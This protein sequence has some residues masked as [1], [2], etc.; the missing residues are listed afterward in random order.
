MAKIT[1]LVNPENTSE[2]LYPITT[3]EAVILKTGGVLS[4]V[5]TEFSEHT[6]KK[7]NP[8]QVTAA[9]IGLGNVTNDAQVKRSEM[10]IPGGVAILDGSGKISSSQLPAYVD[11][12]LEY[13]GKAA[14]PGTGESGKIYV[15]L[16]TNL[17]YRWSGSRYVEIPQSLALGETE[18]TAYS[19][20]KGKATRDDLDSHTSNKSNPHNVT[21][22]QIGA[23]EVVNRET[24]VTKDSDNLHYPSS[25]AVY[26]FG[27]TKID[28][29]ALEDLS[30]VYEDLAVLR[31][32]PQYLNDD[33][34]K[35]ARVNIGVEERLETLEQDYEDTE[36]RYKEIQNFD[37]AEL[38]KL[39]GQPMI[40]FGAG[41]PTES[42]VP[43]NWI[44]FNPITGEGYNWDGTPSALGQ[45]YINTT[46]TYGGR[47][48]AARNG[49]T[50]L[51]W[52][53]F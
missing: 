26:D 9:Q 43:D 18:S 37:W 2:T 17:V 48:I 38:P 15:A 16:D 44:Q 32:T 53:N 30:V 34:K 46:V 10:G 5:V 33:E 23:E 24:T 29:T 41:A 39:C 21:T 11:D 27:K 52:L 7:D 28:Y 49:T 51:K 1:K 3:D 22:S 36:I 19:G 45:Q 35:Q 50:G 40:L 47:Y 42:I 25:K 31:K 4:D 6:K 12:V 13:S 20:S 8:H 14:F